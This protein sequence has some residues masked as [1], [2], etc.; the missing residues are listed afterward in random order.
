ESSLPMSMDADEKRSVERGLYML[1]AYQSRWRGE[2][3]DL[4][5]YEIDGVRKPYVEIQFS[6]FICEWRKRPIMY[7]G[8]IDRIMRSKMTVLVVNVE[9]KTTS[10]VLS[11]FQQQV[12]PNHQVTGY[13]LASQ[14]LNLDI[15]ETIWDMT[16]V[17]SRK[18]DP[19]QGAWMVY[20]I[21]IEK[22]F[23]RAST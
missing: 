11:V 4:M 13:Y 3:F 6:I 1:E 21:D 18:P 19:K 9:T 20:G 23:G 17:S 16:F 7:S 2:P 5:W 15:K 12:K 10:Q 8:V 14:S 22:D